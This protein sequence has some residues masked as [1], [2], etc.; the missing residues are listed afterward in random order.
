MLIQSEQEIIKSAIEV[1]KKLG[2]KE[3]E[4]PI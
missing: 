3:I 2:Y 4:T 1:L